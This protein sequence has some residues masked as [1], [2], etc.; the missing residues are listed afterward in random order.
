[1]KNLSIAFATILLVGAII[2]FY[3]GSERK[4]ILSEFRQYMSKFNKKYD[5]P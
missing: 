5:T 3:P 1:M 2:A 4:E